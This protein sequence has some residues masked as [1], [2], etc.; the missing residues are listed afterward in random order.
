FDGHGRNADAFEE[1]MIY[2]LELN[3]VRP[4]Y[5]VV[6]KNAPEQLAPFLRKFASW[7]AETRQ[8]R[9]EDPAWGGDV[10]V[11]VKVV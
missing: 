5:E 3:T 11:S 10:E 1:T 6:V 4:P 7:I 9:R 2:R 8:D